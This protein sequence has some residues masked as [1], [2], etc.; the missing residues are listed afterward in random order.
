VFETLFKYPRLFA[1]HRTG[2]SA[3]ARERFLQH[4]VSQGL[5][6]ATVLRRARELLLIAERIDITSGEPISLRPWANHH[7]RR[8]WPAREPSPS[9]CQ[10]NVTLPA[11]APVSSV[12]PVTIAVDR[13]E[14]N[15][16]N[17]AISATGN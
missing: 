14:S 16:V 13:I 10:I 11:G 9:L 12:V 1:R 2:P 7:A 17:L 3:E 5:A 4:C 6:G 15:T 8:R